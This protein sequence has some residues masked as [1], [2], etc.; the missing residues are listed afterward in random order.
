MT[1]RRDTL[2]YSSLH[3]HDYYSLLD[4]YGSPKE[5]LDRAR[6]I[7][8]KAFATTNHGNAYS[9][10]YYDLIKKD[11]P[12]IKMIYGCELY[13]CN[14]VTV[15]D[16]SNRYFHLIC[17]VRNE[18]GRK[19]LN[20]VITKSNF[21][22]F[23]YKPRCEIKDIKP[24]AENFVITSACLAGKLASENDFNKCVEYINEYKK[25]F[26]YFYLEMQSHH[27]EDQ[28][29]YNRKILNLSEITNTPFI[30]TT[31]S[32]AAT[33][34][35]LKYQDYLVKIGRNSTKNDK[36]AIENSEIYEGCYMQSE[37][38][39]HE[40]MDKQIGYENVCIGLENT[41]KIA[42][43]I[44]DVNMP[45]QEPQLPTFPLPYGFESN[46]DYMCYLVEKG[47]YERGF[48]KFD[49][50][51]KKIYQERLKYE[52]S[53]IHQMK[54]DGYF[55]FVQDFINACMERGVE[56]GKGRGCFTPGTKVLLSN[57]TTKNIEE[58]SIGENVITHLGNTKKVLNTFTYDCK[59][60][61]YEIQAGE[62]TA[63]TCTN[64]HQI[65]AVKTTMCY[66]STWSKD[67]KSK[68]FC[69]PNC[70]KYMTCKYKKEFKPQW[71]EAEKL[72]KNDYVVYPNAD[73][74]IAKDDYNKV[75]DLSKY[76][77][78]EYFF[79]D[80]NFVW[81]TNPFT[82][83][84]IESSKVNRFIH[85]DEEFIKVVGWYISQG[86]NKNSNN[87]RDYKIGFVH[88]SNKQKLI[89]E[90]VMLL[91]QIFGK[92]VCVRHH[93]EKKA[94][95]IIVHS[96]ILSL[97]F[98]NLFGK[99][100]INKKIPDEFMNM[101]LNLTYNLIR[102]LWDGD[103]SYCIGN[104]AKTKYSTINY[105]L[106][107]QIQRLLSSV[108]IPSYIS[109][110][111]YAQY[112]W[113]D[114]YGVVVH[115]R[116]FIKKLNTICNNQFITTV[117][118]NKKTHHT[119]TYIDNMYTYNKIC[120][121]NIKDYNGKVYDLQVED[122][123]S[124]VV[125]S[126]AVHNSASGSLVCYSMHITDIDPIKYNL[127]FERFLN[128]ERVG[129]PDI[130]TDVS[131]R[132]A[133]IDYL[134]EKFGEERVCQIINYSYITPC[135]AI[136]DVGKVLGFPYNQMQKLSQ[137]FTMPTWDECIDTSPSILVD[138]TQYTELFDIAKH[139]SN[140]VK[141][142]SIHAG[143]VGIVDTSVMDYM[144]MK[145]GTNGEHVIQVDKHYVENIG[146]IKF[147]ILGL[148]TLKL[149]KEI[150]DDL[151]L[152][153]W[154]Y[155]INNPEFE[156]DKQT[157]ELLSSG[158]TNGV[159]Q[160]ESAGMKDLM[161]RLQP[162]N[163]HDVAA[164]V[165]LYRPDSMGALE[166]YIEIATGEKEPE[167]IHK[168][169]IPI[170]G[171]TNG[172]LLYQ[173]QLLDIV[174]TFGGRTYGQA[175]LF[176]RGIGKKDKEL[177]KRESSKLRQEI[178]DNGYPDDIANKIADNMSE[179]GGYIFNQSH[180]YSYAVLCFEIA[181]FKSHY[182][183][184]FFKALFNLNKNKAGAINKY[185][186]DAKYFHV[187]ILP[188]DI[189]RSKMDFTVYENHVLFGLSAVSGIGETLAKNIIEERELNGMYK[190]FQ[191]LLNRVP[192]T[193]A[194]M[195][196]LI[197][198]GAIPCKNKKKRLIQY[199]K[200]M[201]VP[202]T[203]KPVQSLP[204]YNTLKYDWEM[205][206]SDYEF[207]SKGKR[208]VY[209]KE[210]LLKDYNHL[211]EKKFKLEQ[212]KRYQKYIDENKK[213]LENDEFWEFEALQIFINDNPFDAAYTF[214]TPFEDVKD[215]DK[216]T[217]VGIIAKVQKKKDKHGKQFA[218]INLYSSFGLVEGIVWHTQLKE[219]ED[220]VKKGEKV[221][222]LCKKDSEE[223]VVVEQMKS[224]ERWLEYA[225]KKIKVA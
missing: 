183:T 57:G 86:W 196:S 207:E 127:I 94:I 85:V 205:N 64:N 186:L 201:Y 156:Q 28:S 168:D 55:L 155:D 157:Y 50:E 1:E 77:N 200:S 224:Y 11:Y 124:Y 29:I 78:S 58:V 19:D 209:D 8:L 119:R 204:T 118:L 141:T 137:K 182:S 14:D 26:P 47:W 169:M 215:G 208:I 166:E 220:L 131:D 175:D 177:V 83:N 79:F 91:Q 44:D 53:V 16:K 25:A 139:L 97:F 171:R 195:I 165:S 105:N 74:N 36:N 72:T 114:E 181:Y 176:R 135:V 211:K 206:L 34:D 20:K 202:L 63:I 189:N 69:T 192:L 31:D 187:S 46:Y 217:L 160:V 68:Q 120:S 190:S 159:F 125:G 33:K 70:V 151:K 15:K 172:C 23:Y 5:M 38:E 106:A 90:N 100:A 40:C 214:L 10:I 24:Y 222:I 81:Y 104:K 223:K 65:Y 56:V 128:P 170:L 123:T 179:K 129:L 163:L 32:H 158:K 21:E 191:D 93:N 134:I 7:G 150:K 154:E 96:K 52:I 73:N 107:K 54:F 219:Y 197:K 102:S 17:L 136:T 88:H 95:Q 61:M 35:D 147:D 4:G 152:N 199:L 121:I 71:I 60:K 146:I 133:V 84:I 112:N 43:L 89:N 51:K 75:Y 184:Y 143:G 48:D 103:G 9:F 109:V 108:K 115:G 140:R 194:Q 210:H 110:R 193:K 164:V 148:A 76:D 12:D 45:F 212:E 22:G 145:I 218:F 198:A 30:I 2:A 66:K 6:E 149:V 216:C 41:N 162:K 221:A 42:D 144:P 99:Y 98:E 67:K 167:Y 62:Q 142:V 101:P 111:K 132:D 3:N 138:N 87:Q 126:M 116:D 225:K 39:I 92:Y 178:M 188:P 13:E 180:G 213:Y 113:R 18:Q 153:P 49:D 122:D 37:E 117:D 173:E 82:G 27:H 59:E 185:I 203:F 174:R 130:D 80:D 161:V